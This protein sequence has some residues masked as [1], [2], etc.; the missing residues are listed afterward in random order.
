[1]ARG[2]VERS[3]V[4]LGRGHKEVYSSTRSRALCDGEGRGWWKIVVFKILRGV[5]S[6]IIFAPV[7]I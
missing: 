4:G 3:Q 5:R 7:S 6:F 2:T 1:M